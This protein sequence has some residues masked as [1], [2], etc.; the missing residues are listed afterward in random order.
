MD[1]F[2]YN[3]QFKRELRA[4]SHPFG[5]VSYLESVV[6]PGM[7]VIDIGANRGLTTVAIA[8]NAGE[9]GR[10][11]AFEPVPEYYRTLRANLAGNGVHNARTY[12]RALGK[13]EGPTE[14]YKD[15]GGSGIVPQ[16][17][18]ETLTVDV[19]TLDA[20][21][22]EEG[23]DQIDLISMDCEGSE[24]LVLQGAE[25]TVATIRPRIFCE[26]HRPR[27]RTLGQSLE[28]LVRW[29][30]NRDYEVTPILIDSWNRDTD[31][32]QCTHIF[33]TPRPK[34]N[35]HGSE[36]ERLE[37]KLADLEA[38]WPAHSVPPS[39]LQEREELEE[40]LE[41]ARRRAPH[42]EGE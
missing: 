41:E 25:K 39:M 15:G 31:F 29:L 20:F 33:A 7:T 36:I 6:E 35:S 11:Y 19:E 22:D 8:I 40:K 12:R 17:G 21:A 1:T 42:K 28:E 18:A 3:E 23:L 24:L 10:V 32:E 13:S 30:E 26:V 2:I 27:L 4:D 37:K 5:E 38:R 14:Y 34:E 16:D 9:A